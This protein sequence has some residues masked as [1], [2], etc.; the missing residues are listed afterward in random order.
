MKL[1]E[2]IRL[3]AMM[4]PQVFRTLSDDG[5]TCAMGS[6]SKAIGVS[7]Q[8]FP[9][10]WP[11][12]YAKEMPCPECAWLCNN[13]AW[14]IATH[15]ND[16]HRSWRMVRLVV[17]RTPQAE[18]RH[19]NRQGRPATLRQEMAISSRKICARGRQK[20]SSR[21]NDERCKATNPK[22]CRRRAVDGIFCLKHRQESQ[23]RVK[24]AQA[25]IRKLP[26]GAPQEK[27]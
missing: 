17:C 2:A 13:V 4:G 1:S 5:G 7:T 19:G 18:S 12:V 6:A 24:L 10:V 25:I 26:I 3:G 11:W 9:E 21:M 15:L 27:P 8:Q 20:R 22:K 16:H 14:V 23:N